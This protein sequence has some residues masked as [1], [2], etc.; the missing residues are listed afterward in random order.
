FVTADAG[1]PAAER[2]GGQNGDRAHRR[3]TSDLGPEEPAAAQL[4]VETFG[5][6]LPRVDPDLRTEVRAQPTR[7]WR[8]GNIDRQRVAAR[9]CHH[10]ALN[11]GYDVVQLGLSYGRTRTNFRHIH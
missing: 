4:N 5:A 2:L 3:Q 8:S 10:S 1:R 9:R 11:S 7:A 6:G